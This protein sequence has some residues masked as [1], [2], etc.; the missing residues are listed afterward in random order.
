VSKLGRT[1]ALKSA[2][3]NSRMWENAPMGPNPGLLP[4]GTLVICRRV[5]SISTSGYR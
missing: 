3:G 5:S 1:T 4:A 2:A